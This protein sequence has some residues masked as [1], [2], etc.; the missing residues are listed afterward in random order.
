MDWDCECE[1][2]GMAD[3]DEVGGIIVS[4]LCDFPA[5]AR[6]FASVVIDRV[7]SGVEINLM[8]VDGRGYVI[9]DW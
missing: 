2:R 3:L 8:W 6:W 5:G 1:A 7:W 4:I 9:F